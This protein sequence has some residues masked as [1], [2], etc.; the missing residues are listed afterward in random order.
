MGAL[1]LQSINTKNLELKMTTP[2]RHLTLSKFTSPEEMNSA[3]VKMYEP[4][5]K[6]IA[7]LM[8][9]VAE[10]GFNDFVSPEDL[11]SLATVAVDINL[12]IPV[13][14]IKGTLELKHLTVSQFATINDMNIAKVHMYEA[15]LKEIEKLLNE[16]SLK[17]YNDFLNPDDLSTLA[18]A[19]NEINYSIPDVA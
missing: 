1:V 2:M 13:I 6:E 16:K 7:V 17:G 10:K 19:A 12:H 15:K 8:N 9:Y 11:E 14:N 5:L 18:T 4:K 3:K